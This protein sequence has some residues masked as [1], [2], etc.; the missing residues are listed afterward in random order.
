MWTSRSPAGGRQGSLHE[1]VNGSRMRSVAGGRQEAENDETF[2][3]YGAYY[4]DM[5]Q[6]R[7]RLAGLACLMALRDKERHA[8]LSHC[9]HGT[10][11]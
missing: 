8:T 3:Y 11:F 6:V 10:V 9:S 5:D 7:V 1:D 4:S 2:G